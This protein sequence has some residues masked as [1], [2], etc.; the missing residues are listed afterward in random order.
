MRLP[1]LA[2]AYRRSLAELSGALSAS[3]QL[4]HEVQQVQNE[5]RTSQSSAPA[6]HKAA[7]GCDGHPA[8]AGANADAAAHATAAATAGDQQEV[9]SVLGLFSETFA[10]V[11]RA[12]AAS[13]A[14]HPHARPY[15]SAHGSVPKLAPAYPGSPFGGACGGRVPTNSLSETARTAGVRSTAT[16]DGFASI[17]HLQRDD[18]DASFASM[19]SVGASALFGGLAGVAGGSVHLSQQQQQQQQQQQPLDVSS[20]LE[21]FSDLVVHKLQ[22]QSAE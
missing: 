18:S 7:E 19:S 11:Q 14:L 6:L 9:E 10:G 1:R 5:I 15:T 8:D 12:V 13:G 2:S 17:G 22:S 21:Q 16:A 4:L 20:L 3:L